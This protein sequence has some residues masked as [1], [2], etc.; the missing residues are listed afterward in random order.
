MIRMKCQPLL[1]LKVKEKQEA[2]IFQNVVCCSYNWRFK[3]FLFVYFSQYQLGLFVLPSKP[4]PQF[5]M[6]Y[7]KTEKTTPIQV[8]SLSCADFLKYFSY[9]YPEYIVWHVM[10]LI[11]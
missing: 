9:F 2:K 5:D 8:F 1:S 4:I 10:E 3:V 11:S 7:F 6:Y